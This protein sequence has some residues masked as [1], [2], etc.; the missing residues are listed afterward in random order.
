M[1]DNDYNYAND[2]QFLA[3]PAQQQHAYLMA[4][5]PQYAKADPKVQG[6]YIA[7]LR[8]YDQPT[9]F[10]QQR[11]PTVDTSGG[12]LMRTV[13]GVGR[14]IED[15]VGGTYQM[16]RHPLDTATGMA[17]QTAQHYKQAQQEPTM[18][19]KVAEYGAAVP[20]LGPF[21]QQLG[22]RA[23]QG[24]VAGAIA[25]GLTATAAPLAAQ[26]AVGAVPAVRSGIGERMYTPEGKLKPG[27]QMASKL[28]GGAAGEATGLPYAG[29]V[30]YLG[31]PELARTIF[32]DPR[33]PLEITRTKAMGQLMQRAVR[34]DLKPPPV[35]E[36]EPYKQFTARPGVLQGDVSRTSP[37]G[38]PATASPSRGPIPNVGA[39]IQNVEPPA[40]QEKV[41]FRAGMKAQLNRGT[42]AAY[43]PVAGARAPSQNF[44]GASRMVPTVRTG[45]PAETVQGEGQDLISRMRRVAIPGEEPGPEDLKRAGDF[46]Q[47]PLSKLQRLAKF[48]DKLAQNEIN[49]RL[50]QNF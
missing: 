20:M 32:P 40:V 22:Q 6:S 45:L 30:G 25:E 12:T 1:P 24:D 5:D 17:A 27:V 26:E 39:S 11:A 43:D 19:G 44:P 10:E 49:R 47:A 8:G 37:R 2:P 34:D 48:G 31:G 41:P 38:G 16:L 29:L 15:V 9:Q 13:E 4:T 46:T 23:G 7:H 3:A 18:L 50:K 36:P 42:G 35:P 21:G 14:G 33:T 28:A